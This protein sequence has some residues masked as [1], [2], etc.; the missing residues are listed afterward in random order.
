VGI[1][2]CFVAVLHFLACNST[3]KDRAGRRSWDGKLRAK[4]SWYALF[5]LSTGPVVS[6]SVSISVSTQ[7]SQ[8]HAGYQDGQPHEAIAVVNE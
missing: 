2:Q 3:V 6:I 7:L 8:L 5:N 4:H 1:A